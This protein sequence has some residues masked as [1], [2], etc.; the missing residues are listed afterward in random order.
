M[1]FD[2]GIPIVSTTEI[3]PGIL[4]LSSTRKTSTEEYRDLVSDGRQP[5]KGDL[6]YSR[7]ASLGSAA[8]VGTDEPFCMGQD[9]CM[10]T[11]SD[12]DQLFLMY[13]LNSS[14]VRSQLESVAIGSTFLR[15]NI[16]QIGCLT[17]CC[18][19]PQEQARIASYLT[20]VQDSF[21]ELGQAIET[22]IALLR[23]YR[24][25]LITAAVTGQLDIRA[26]EKQMETL[27]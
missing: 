3:K 22:N 24:S 2:T 11:S 17:V 27:V 1:Y 8:Y 6:I 5:R 18:P 10:M 19:P 12:Q 20:G 25:A 14:F 15:I 9:V 16:A 13:Q 7:N 4:D 21:R 23:E 26:H